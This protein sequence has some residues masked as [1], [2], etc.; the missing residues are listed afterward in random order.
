MT[1]QGE[2]SVSAMKA[3]VKDKQLYV[4]A[5]AA[6][7]DAETNLFINSDNDP[8]TGYLGW[9]FKHTGPTI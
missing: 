2:A 8:D 9:E 1:A 6:S 4:L 5:Q 7:F 3:F